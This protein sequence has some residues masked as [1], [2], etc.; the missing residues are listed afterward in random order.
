MKRLLLGAVGLI[1]LGTAA[2][3]GGQFTSDLPGQ[4]SYGPLTGSETI[5]V[6][7][8]LPQGAQPQT[9]ALQLGALNLNGWTNKLIGGDFSTNPAQRLSTTKGVTAL[10]T[11][12]PTAAVI[13]ADR[14]WTVAP[15]AGVTLTLDST[16]STA[17][18]PSLNNTK[19]Y[20]I[21]RT[22][23]GA[24]GIICTGQT[25]DTKASDPFIGQQT[26]FSFYEVNGS[27]MSAANGQFTVNIDYTSAAD[28]VGTQATLG[29][30]GL[31]GSKFALADAGTLA[32]GPTNYTNAVNG[33]SVGAG[34][35]APGVSSV[36]GAPNTAAVFAGSTSWSRYGVYASIP[37]NIP[38]TTTAVT[39]IS[40]SIC[41]TPV[42]TTAVT[43]DYI[44]IE[45]AQLE[46]RPPASTLP[47]VASG[48]LIGSTGIG[49]A[50]TP[51]AAVANVPEPSP[52]ERRPLAIEQSL[53]YYYWYFNYEQ[54]SLGLTLNGSCEN[55]AATIA[56]CNVIFPVPMR[57]VP[58]V[59]FTDGFQVFAQVGETSV[60]ACTSLG[61]S[62]TLASVANNT[63]FLMTC[64]ASVGAAGTA[65][66][67]MSLGTSG[68]SGIISASAE[69]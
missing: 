41:W 3:A 35:L 34:T 7:T 44:E 61:Y 12:S 10:A 64:T 28:G 32:S 55:T 53:A 17:V 33:I 47:T 26:V 5:P 19:A 56:N 63:G 1:A 21:A 9:I 58:L 31:N 59:K 8:N 62:T 45:G 69:P 67:W 30:A 66:S 68:G 20:R 6:D 38:G 27:T 49:P 60:S 25:F 57:I 39:A 48:T 22:S 46:V 24:A 13:G 4:G 40:V 18:V 65:N 36:T 54:Q 37:T 11:L 15:A 23:S 42:A 51:V 50:S 29:Y 2:L 52:F 16:A 14:W 43:T